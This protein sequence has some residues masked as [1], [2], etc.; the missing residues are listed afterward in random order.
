MSTAA[1]LALIGI[2]LLAVVMMA[3]VPQQGAATTTASAG[4][5]GVDLAD[6][7]TNPG[8]GYYTNGYAAQTTGATGQ[9]GTNGGTTDGVNITD[10]G[11]DVDTL[12]RVIYGEARGQSAAAQQGVVSVVLNRTNTFGY[13]FGQLGGISGVCKQPLQ[14][15]CMS[16]Q[17]GGSNYTAT[18]AVQAGDPIFN[19]CLA[20]A[21]S[22]IAGN[23]PD[24][25]GGATYY[26]D[27]SISQPSFWQTDGIYK[28][29]QIG[30]LIFG[31]VN[32]ELI[33]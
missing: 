8:Y 1:K 6:A 21:Q 9:Y 14:F 10:P 19:A 23:V 30:A 15:T 22:A 13:S 28:T 27:T 16:A 24:N 31:A 5:D 12:A 25:T 4:G 3:D 32:G 18:M 33:V 2:V 7:Y 29:I 17:Y 20:L 11:G 26:Y